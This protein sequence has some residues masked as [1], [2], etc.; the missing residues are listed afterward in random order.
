[1]GYIFFLLY[2]S[3]SFNGSADA[4]K[5]FYE[6]IYLKSHSYCISVSINKINLLWQF[7]CVWFMRVHTQ[8]KFAVKVWKR[9]LTDVWNWNKCRYSELLKKYFFLTIMQNSEELIIKICCVP[10]TIFLLILALSV[11]LFPIRFS[12]KN[13]FG[14]SKFYFTTYI[15]PGNLVY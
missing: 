6:I 10:T 5:I 8:K 11:F 1:M 12:G 7:S 13:L 2:W 3:E 15:F 14:K 9:I 4:I